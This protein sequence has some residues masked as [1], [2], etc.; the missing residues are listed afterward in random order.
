M[1]LLLTI[2]HVIICIVLILVIL[3]Q[4]GRGQG[5]SGPSFGGGNVQSLFG[6][7]AAD[8]LTKATSVCAIL[9]LFTAIGLG[10]VESRKSRTLMNF[11]KTQNAPIDVDAIKKALERVKQEGAADTKAAAEAGATAQTAATTATANATETAQA[12]SAAVP[13]AAEGAVQ[14]AQAAATAAA[15]Q[16]KAQ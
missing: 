15:D 13:G 6:T 1:I 12:A 3:L 2:V 10:Y 5:L 16:A 9:F 4:A 7:G 11:S 8:F 14:T